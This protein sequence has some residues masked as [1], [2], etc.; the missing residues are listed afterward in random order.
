MGWKHFVWAGAV[1]VIILIIAPL[2]ILP[3]SHDV[4]KEVRDWIGAYSGIFLIIA[5]LIAAYPVFL[6]LDEEKI[7]T[8]KTRVEIIA[9]IQSAL[10]AENERVGSVSKIVDEIIQFAKGKQHANITSKKM[11][12]LPDITHV[13]DEIA[14]KV[15]KIPRVTEERQNFVKIAN[16]FCK[17]LEPDISTDPGD[18][19]FTIIV[20]T[21]IALRKAV[22]SYKKANH[23]YRESLTEDIKRYEDQILAH[24]KKKAL[25][26]R[27]MLLSLGK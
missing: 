27:S 25:R 21:G 11:T 24:E 4:A 15:D 17:H 9:G 23:E 14:A 5:A 10:S 7:G 20:N 13:T 3:F 22:D 12:C 16:E 26:S 6:Q 18:Y 19:Y 8:N 2:A 1:V